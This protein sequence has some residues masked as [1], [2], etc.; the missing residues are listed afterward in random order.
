MKRITISLASLCCLVPAA[1]G[2]WS[3]PTLLANVNST[4]TDGS[5]NLS[6]D[7]LTLY[8]AQYTINGGDIHR[9]T[10][11]SVYGTFGTPVHLPELSSPQEDWS[12]CT[13]LD[14]LEIFWSSQRPGGPGGPYDLWRADR[15]STSVPFNT[16]VLVA[17]LNTA[18][19]EFGPSLTADGLR[20]YFTTDRPGGLGSTDIWT[21]TRP[22]WSS[23]F[24][25]ATP[26][27]ELNSTAAD[28]DTRVSPDNLVFFFS[29][30]RPGG[31]GTDD[32]W[33]ASRVSPLLPFGTP[34]NLTAVNAPETERNPAVA[35]F[36]DELIFGST[37]PG[38]PGGRDLYS[39]RFRGLVGFGIAGPA[40]NQEL[41]FSDPSSQGRVYVAASS[42]GNTPGTQIG[43]HL[44]PLNVDLLMQLTIGGLPPVM[45]GYVGTLNNDGVGSGRIALAGFPQIIG[46]RFFTAFLVLDPAGPF[47]IK[48]VSNAHEVLVQ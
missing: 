5:P 30:G 43:P 39:S 40:S 4:A 3:T 38:G 18:A 19:N 1:T 8:F 41:R 10:R 29:S 44:L 22:N 9:A 12:P 48:G 13:R 14:D 28:R 33:M 47:G 26:V 15:A 17:E 35:M 25:T 37:R 11:T 32:L 36:T 24:G 34:I 45:T 42:L 46:L 2:Q 21:A 31:V 23:P 7:G 27:T 20:I 6:F 16:P